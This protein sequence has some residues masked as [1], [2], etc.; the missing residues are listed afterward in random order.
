MGSRLHVKL[1]TYKAPYGYFDFEEGHLFLE[2]ISFN[3]AYQKIYMVLSF[4]KG[5]PARHMDLVQLLI[6]VISIDILH[7]RLLKSVI[8]EYCEF[9]NVRAVHISALFVFL[10]FPQK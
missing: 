7:G 10:K 4:C 1:R 8:A 2:D 9:R 5:L 3:I 6:V